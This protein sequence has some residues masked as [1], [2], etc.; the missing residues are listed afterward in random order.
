M[1]TIEKYDSIE[2][3]L[4][5]LDLNMTDKDGLDILKYIRVEKSKATPIIVMSGVD[6]E[7][8]IVRAFNEGA[9]EYI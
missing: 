4:V 5:I 8:T 2:P 6:E 7:G 9:D 3:D 1:E